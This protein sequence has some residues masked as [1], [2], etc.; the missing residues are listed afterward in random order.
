[1]SIQAYTPLLLV[2]ILIVA[3]LGMPL[4]FAGPMHHE[5]GCPF[6]SG[7]AAFCATNFLQH[8]THWQT[9]FAVVLGEL[10]VIAGL[11]LA[12]LYQ[13]RVLMLPERSF[14]RIRMRGRTPERPTLLQELFSRGILNRKEPHSF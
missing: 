11:A 7:E 5:M 4:L 6:V 8:I 13:W 1:M 12:V 3:L 14:A 9:A 2:I 10:L